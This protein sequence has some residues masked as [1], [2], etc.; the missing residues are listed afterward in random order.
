MN[1]LSVKAE[2]I[3]LIQELPENA[4]LEDILYKI[5]VKA[6]IEEGLKEIEEGKGIPHEEAMERISNWL[7]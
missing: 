3:K 6:K 5:H 2:V 1:E 4:T 7:N